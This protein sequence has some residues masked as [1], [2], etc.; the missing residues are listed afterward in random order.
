MCINGPYARVFLVE[1][2]AHTLIA[3]E[4][5][6]KKIIQYLFTSLGTC[7]TW[8]Y[9]HVTCTVTNHVVRNKTS[10]P[11]ARASKET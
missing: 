4:N 9:F 1:S 2:N 6:G 10:A 7:Q 3:V 8:C 11:K 5:A